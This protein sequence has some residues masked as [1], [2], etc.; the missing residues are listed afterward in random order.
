M[1][2]QSS[3]SVL[4]VAP[5]GAG[6]SAM[7]LVPAALVDART[8]VLIT[9]FVALRNDLL[10]KSRAAG[11]ACVAWQGE[12]SA[13]L[14]RYLNAKLVLAAVEHMEQGSFRSLLN[15]L[16][17][18]QK[19][20]RIVIDEAHL[21]LIAS[22]WRPALKHY[23]VLTA[24][25]VPLLLLTA[26]LPVAQEDDLL[27]HM[28]IDRDCVRVFRVSTVRRN[29]AHSVTHLGQAVGKGEAWCGIDDIALFVRQHRASMGLGPRKTLVYLN[30]KNSVEC[31]AAAFPKAWAFHRDTKDGQS[32]LAAFK[33]S[34]DGILF[35]TSAVDHGVDLRDIDD[36]IHAS[37]PGSLIAYLQGSGRCGRDGRPGVAI[38]LWGPGV[39]EFDLKGVEE[40]EGRKQL[41]A[42]KQEGFAVDAARCRRVVLDRILDGDEGRTRCRLG[43]EELCDVCTR[44]AQHDNYTDRSVVLDGSGLDSSSLGTGFVSA[45]VRCKYSRHAALHSRASGAWGTPSR[46]WTCNPA[47][48]TISVWEGRNGCFPLSNSALRS[49]L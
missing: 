34:D 7:A 2:N 32:V 21:P 6:K 48:C 17:G 23:P 33:D 40:E 1:L 19:L 29:L 36:A 30:N 31:L 38:L 28:Q 37:C 39:Q 49:S 15:T 4:M 16:K 3:R 42:Y 47:D 46:A 11:V 20:E 12:D 27:A 5:T 43:E 41:A 13:V 9:P 8:T 18:A 22:R 10:V 35:C 44:H 24:V 14:G 26:T 25:G 45:S